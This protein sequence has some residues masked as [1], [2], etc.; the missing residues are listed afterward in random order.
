[1]ESRSLETVDLFEYL[2]LQ[3]K[4]IGILS[5]HGVPGKYDPLTANFIPV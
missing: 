1:M 4:A 3:I 2:C 5:I